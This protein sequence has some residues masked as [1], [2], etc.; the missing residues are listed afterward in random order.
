[1]ISNTTSPIKRGLI[2]AKANVIP[3]IILQI[4]ALSIVLAYYFYQPF[5]EMLQKVSVYKESC[6][7]LFPAISTTIF[8]AFLPFLMQ[9]FQKNKAYH[10]KFSHLP[11]LCL[12][13]AYKGIE[14]EL[15]YRLQ[16]YI[17]GTEVT[18]S[19]VIPKVLVD[20]FVYNPVWAVHTIVIFYLW[21]DSGFNLREAIR[22]VKTNYV[23]D[24]FIPPL[25]SNWFVWIP[26]VSV[27]YCL[28]TPLQLPMQNIV[29]CIYV[30]LMTVLSKEA[31]KIKIL[32]E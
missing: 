14:V 19:V 31:V 29:L 11:I 4:S 1:M 16:A 24:K 20:Q 17:F 2:A 5:G 8:G 28:P 6:G 26:A 21:K 10:E 30:L 12:F 27:I 23:S 22:Q 9:F 15:L 18:P 25:V 3:A 7:L 13:W 32:E